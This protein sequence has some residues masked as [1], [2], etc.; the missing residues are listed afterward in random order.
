MSDTLPPSTPAALSGSS[1]WTDVAE[2]QPNILVVPLGSCEQH[3]PHLPLDTDTRI[4]AEVARRWAA[5][6]S[7]V[8]VGPSMAYGAS[9][10]HAS[11]PGTVSIGTDALSMVLVEL[12]RSADDFAGLVWVCGHGGNAEALDIA[13]GRLAEEG[14]N[15]LVFMC[16][17]PG[18]DAHAGRSE[19]SMI[20]ALDHSAVR[21]DRLEEGCVTPWSDIRDAV[22]E[23]GVAAVAANGVLGDPRDADPQA[24]EAMLTAMVDS[25]DAAVTAW[26]D[27]RH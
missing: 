11:F 20:A 14:R 24:G 7:D 5:G 27:E 8:M 2:R 1:T 25:L 18:G 15:P 19:T 17:V 21:A 16:S 13:V 26:A 4:A 23:R 9:G 22:M 12:A 6:R 10:E 3:G